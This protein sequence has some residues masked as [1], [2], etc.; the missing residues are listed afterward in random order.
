ASHSAGRRSPCAGV[1][2]TGKLTSTDLT[3][4][5]AEGGCGHMSLSR[6][7]IVTW[8]AAGAAG[9]AL[10]FGSAAAFADHPIPAPETRALGRVFDVTR[11]GAKGDGVTIDSDVINQVI[12]AAA[13]DGRGGTVYFPAG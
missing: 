1:P 11:F 7:R 5:G 9:A 8:G 4:W 13:A 3:T 10:P 2:R 6:R 12:E